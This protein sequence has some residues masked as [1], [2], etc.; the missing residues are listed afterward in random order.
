MPYI[1]FTVPAY[2]GVP[3]ALV[4]EFMKS[5]DETKLK[6]LLYILRHAPKTVTV[7][8]LCA[9]TGATVN[10]VEQVVEFW[11]ES[12]VLDII[13]NTSS[14]IPP[15]HKKINAV[16]VARVAETDDAL[17]FLLK[18]SQELLGRVMTRSET[19]SLFAIYDWAGMSPDVILMLIQY[20]VS[21]ERGNMP[22]IEK[23][24][25][26]WRENGINNYE[27]AEKEIDR[28]K[29]EHSAEEKVKSIVGIYNRNLTKSEKEHLNK[30]VFEWDFSWD[31]I[32][33]SFE[34]TAEKT[35]KASFAYMN[36]ILENWHDAGIKTRKEIESKQKTPKNKGNR[37]FTE[38][39][40]K[41]YEEWGRSKLMEDDQ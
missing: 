8:D 20:C 3:V 4:D 12:G 27:S 40:I 1:D 5:A 23:L 37:S 2:F 41:D 33:E 22:F 18:R 7:E 26:R 36:K 10:V 32:A 29:K 21:I 19:E 38:A 14:A 25:Y 24:A 11:K 17:S 30:W 6:V 15:R 31:M 13:P 16:E 34:R 39:D 9:A 35:G 28:L